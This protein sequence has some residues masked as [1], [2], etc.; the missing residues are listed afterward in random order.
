MHLDEIVK[1]YARL[2]EYG[3]MKAY[4]YLIC[5]VTILVVRLETDAPN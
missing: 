1:H 4:H 5:L 3:T 2:Q